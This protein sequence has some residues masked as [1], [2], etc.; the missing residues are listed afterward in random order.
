MKRIIFCCLTALCLSAT[1]FYCHAAANAAAP[2]AY[3]AL[4]S[5][6]DKAELSGL[7]LLTG[8]TPGK[9]EEGF[10]RLEDGSFF[11]DG[12]K[13]GRRAGVAFSVSLN[14]KEPLT[15]FA[16]GDSRCE[17]V[18]SSATADY[19]LYLDIA[20]ID[21]TY[22]YGVKAE[23]P[24]RRSNGAW[25]TRTVMFQPEKPIRS[26]SMYL[27]FRNMP[28]KAWFKSPELLCPDQTV[29]TIET[30]SQF[31]GLTVKSCNIVK[32]QGERFYV[33]D[34]AIDG[35]IYL[36]AADNSGSALEAAG[37]RIQRDKTKTIVSNTTGK[38]RAITL[39][40]AIPVPETAVVW[41]G[42]IDKQTQLFAPVDPNDPHSTVRPIKRE[43]SDTSAT[44]AGM[45]RLGKWPLAGVGL[46]DGSAVWLAIDPDYP[47]VYRIFYNPI[48]R[49][50][51]IAY[52]L[53]FTAAK[54][55]W[56]LS[57]VDFTTSAADSQFG[58][59]SGWKQ[60]M[61]RFPAA[62][63][64]N[65]PRDAQ[66]VQKMGVWMPFAPISK[67]EGWEDFGFRFK[68]GDGEIAWDDE[69]DILT[70]RYTEPMTWWMSLPKDEPAT[71]E[72]ALKQL[73]KLKEKKASYSLAWD[74]S[75]M[76]DQD[77]QPVGRFMD[78]PW[79]VGIVWSMNSIP[80]LPG[81]FTHYKSMWRP[82][83]V[84]ENYGTPAAA[85]DSP[86]FN[87]GRDGEY[88][89]SSEG[90]VTAVLDFRR[91][92]LDAADRPITFDRDT[93]QLA[94]FRGLVTFE[95]IRKL[96][97]DVR[98]SGRSMMANSTPYQ[99][100]WLTPLMDILGTETNW[101][102]HGTWRPMSHDDLIRKRALIGAK[103]YCFLQN[104]EFEKFSYECSEKFMKR[105]LAYGMFP[106]YFSHNAS[107]GHYFSRPELYNRD[108]PLFKK[109]IP[110][111][112]KLAEAGW[113]PEPLAKVVFD[114]AAPETGAKTAKSALPLT[115]E[116][117]GN[118][119]QIYVSLF[120]PADQTRTVRV[121]LPKTYSGKTLLIGPNWNPTDDASIIEISIDSED[122]AVIQLNR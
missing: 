42:A 41:Y 26:L 62:F 93:R 72:T 102:W 122:V 84:Q 54:S 5:A 92:H 1:V 47:A 59:R 81:E 27:L 34:A 32:P 112:R 80:T 91:E 57:D 77:N 11:I 21:G 121:T 16:R 30:V 9:Y 38:D 87:K 76:F 86:D 74:A 83:Y 117:F 101:N 103:P 120:N 95:Y 28:G 2:I 113:E 10:T 22:E 63:A 35:P 119:D 3:A 13:N 94:Q 56:T 105:S 88:I 44:P 66:G 69:H 79:C 75:V 31:D 116:R 65:L 60:Y 18:D 85:P 49:E 64:C 51:A 37:I 14:Q 7:N 109:Y 70:Y 4:D 97:Q 68:E 6:F 53:G 82:E 71:M 8:K 24:T 45:G 100:F 89:D 29:K 23:F 39:V 33:W 111:C 15:I 17:N 67:V 12:G 115:V 48:V 99:L 55:Q 50:L 104:T 114:S 61:T 46:S 90:Y 52:D 108:R 40:R 107:E 20:Y 96:S 106:G 58:F 118:G 25:S 73:A 36:A 110:L 43:L 98:K 19:S 78:T